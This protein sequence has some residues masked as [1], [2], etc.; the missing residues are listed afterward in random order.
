MCKEFAL[1]TR[2]NK[3]HNILTYN[4]L[5][6]VRVAHI[7]ILQFV[8]VHEI[9]QYVQGIWYCACSGLCSVQISRVTQQVLY[10]PRHVIGHL[11]VV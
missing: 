10:A 8:V 9:A 3:L 2:C 7:K 5:H 4:I 1:D 6:L 11:C